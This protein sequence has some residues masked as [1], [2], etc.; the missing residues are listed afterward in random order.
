MNMDKN[1]EIILESYKLITKLYSRVLQVHERSNSREDKQLLDE[2][3]LF[4]LKYGEEI[5]KITN[6]DSRL[7]GNDK[8]EDNGNYN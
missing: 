7:R 3:Q 4:E 8:E 1:T 5:E 2:T 6:I